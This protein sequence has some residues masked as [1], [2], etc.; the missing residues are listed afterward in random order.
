MLA[1]MHTAYLKA[2]MRKGVPLT[3][4]GIGLTLLLEK[5]VGNNFVHKL[6]AI[7]ILEADFN[8]INKI[9]FAK[10][11]IGLALENNLIPG[12]CFLKKGSNCINAVM[13]KILIC[14]ESRIH[15]HDAC[16]ADNDF[17]DCYNRAAH[18]I[19][20]VSLQGSS[21][22]Q[23]AIDVLLATMETMRFFLRTGF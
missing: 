10:W 22:P 11:M 21:V 3:Q 15:H 16:I 7:C 1:A 19:A 6:W 18:P 12:K 20:A 5:V 4:W 23:P 13:T 2:C 17:G 8:W 14:G 9:I